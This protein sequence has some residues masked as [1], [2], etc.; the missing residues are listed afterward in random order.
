MR[1]NEELA[2]RACNHF[3]LSAS[4]GSRIRAFA[5]LAMS[6]ALIGFSPDVL[7]ASSDDFRSSLA[8]GQDHTVFVKSDGT[9]WAYG[10]NDRG[11]LGD[12]TTA[13]KR[14]PV[15]IGS[16]TNWVSVSAGA[17]HTLALKANGTIWAWGDNTSFQTGDPFVLYLPTPKQVTINPGGP[18]AVNNDWIA[19]DAGDDHNVALRSD[20]SLWVWGRN[21]LG[22]LGTGDTAVRRTPTRLGSAN[23]WIAAAAGADH[24]LG[25]KVDGRLFAWGANQW[26]QLGD[27]TT[28]QRV[29]PV[30]V[31]V[32]GGGGLFDEDWVAVDAGRLHSL[33]MKSNG[34]LW[35]WGANNYG[36]LGVFVSDSCFG[37][38]D[39][40]KSPRR[41][42]STPTGPG[43][44]NSW[45]HFSAGDL[46]SAALKSDGSLWS[47]G[48]NDS[49][50]LGDGTTS[51]R[52][53]PVKV[54]VA[55]DWV[56]VQAGGSHSVGVR[57]NG[58][59]LGWG[60]NVYGQ[61]GDGTS[62]PEWLDP[63][64]TGDDTSNWVSV[65]SAGSYTLAVRSDGTLWS[66]GDNQ[67]GQLGDGTPAD[68]HFAARLGTDRDWVAVAAG[69][70]HAVALKSD[71]S[72]YAWGR[73]A[74]GQLGD[75]TNFDR[76]S[77]VRVGTDNDWQAIA[78]GSGHTVALKS[79]GSLWTW[80]WNSGG[81]L[82]D[83]STTDTNLPARIG[84]DSDWVRISAST[85]HSLAL[86]S[87]GSLWGWGDNDLGSLGTGSLDWELSPVRIGADNDWTDIS[88]GSTHTLALKAD[89]TIWA[90]GSNFAGEL[91]RG[92]TSTYSA[93]PG[94]AGTDDDWVSIHAGG[95]TSTAIKSNGTRWSWGNNNSGQFGNDSTMGETTPVQVGTDKDWVSLGAGGLFSVALKSDGTLWFTGR[96][97][98]G[99]FG[100]GDTDDSLVLIPGG[101]LTIADAGTD[102]FVSFADQVTLDGSNSWTVVPG[103]LDYE[104]TCLEGCG[105]LCLV[106]EQHV[107]PIPLAE[108]VIEDIPEIPG[109]P[110]PPWPGPGVSREFSAPPR[111]GTIILQ[112]R[113]QD[114]YGYSDTDE[115]AVTVFEDVNHA[116]FVA[117]DGNDLAAG[118]MAQPL[119]SIEAAVDRAA[120]FRQCADSGAACS[121][122]SECSGRCV[123]AD[124][125]LQ[126]GEYPA[127][128]TV[129]LQNHMSLFGGY[130]DDWTRTSATTTTISGAATAVSAVGILDP[131]FI[132]GL[133]IKSSDGVSPTDYGFGENSTALY[134]A[135]A[136]AALAIT[137]NLIEAG[138]GGSGGPAPEYDE[139]AASGAPGNDGENG[140]PG[141]VAVAITANGGSGG[142]SGTAGWFGGD[143]GACGYD[144][145]YAPPLV[146][147]ADDG[148]N[149][150]DS[151]LGGE[152]GD[153]CSDA[154]DGVAGRNGTAGAGGEFAPAAGDIFFDGLYAWRGLAGEPGGAGG[155]GGGGGG[156]AAGD[157]S[158]QY[159][160]IG[161][162]PVPVATF[163]GGGGGGGGEGGLGG[164]P[165]S[166][167]ISGSA[168]FG[169]F[170]AAASPSISHNQLVTAGGGAGGDGGDGQ[171]GGIG[172]PGG[173]GGDG[174][175]TQSDS[176]GRGGD[177]G[178]GGQGGGGGGGSGGPSFGIYDAEE[179]TPY[180]TANCYSPAFCTAPAVDRGIGLGGA[181]GAGGFPNGQP[182]LEGLRGEA[183]QDGVY[184]C[185]DPIPPPGGQG[186][187]P[188]DVDPPCS[189]DD[190]DLVAGIDWGGSDITMSLQS[191]TGR[192]IDR[193]T[194]AVD[195]IRQTGATFERYTVLRAEPGTWQV[196]I[197]GLDVPPEGERVALSVT[198]EGSNDAPVA[199]CQDVT[200]PAGP[201]CMAHASVDE[202]SYDPDPDD[203]LSVVE[204]PAGPFGLGVTLVSLT[205]TDGDGLSAECEALVTVADEAA[206]RIE[207]PD[208]VSVAAGPTC[209]VALALP[210]ATASDACDASVTTSSN[211]PAEFPIGTTVVTFSAVD[212][213]GL[214]AFC[215]TKVEVA[216]VT[217]PEITCPPDVV[218]DAP[219]TRDMIGVASAADACGQTPVVTSDAPEQLPLGEFEVTWFAVD[220][221]GNSASCTQQ[222]TVNE[223]P[224]PVQCDLDGD[225]DVDLDDVMV[226]FALR[227]TYSPP[228][229]PAADVNGDGMITI[230]D[231]RDCVLRCT[232]PRC[233][234]Q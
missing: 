79:D 90:W 19:I 95:S 232:L 20:G 214:A 136:R 1:R 155:Y 152:G 211:A 221:V 31:L 55:S 181:G 67:Y 88:T 63:Q 28:T 41:L 17:A 22:Q 129:A 83:G 91:G 190:C 128:N 226:I 99:Q 106:R 120:T 166:G 131:T 46:H 204:V 11:Q 168:S 82:G 44:E 61:L 145:A 107:G 5:Y 187:D 149:G 195:V 105:D 38:S 64:P 207:C 77:P 206:P 37:G 173:V 162:V 56:D 117:V 157:G 21:D 73:N 47:W 78:V 66:W 75:G 25:L 122:D 51:Q 164:D 118:T 101:L 126:E 42:G 35:A 189:T 229:D 139:R 201:T 132:D 216:D 210:D 92:T 93:V 7:A 65:S 146:C 34:T 102:Q 184:V 188:V 175:P 12:G 138:L 68:R 159:T 134:V 227:G 141:P 111:V 45:S 140:S 161:V 215:R 8:T 233:A 230:N 24:T 53:T 154:E 76:N 218:L 100:T 212:D 33:A 151:F 39:C 203:A 127:A 6:I 185:T 153:A 200:V 130:V 147:G 18:T 108:R 176:G 81:Q 135:N 171:L 27:G 208:D 231:G 174:I 60:S 113:V 80:G 209:Q 167:G 192:I 71:G 87:D 224:L 13:D 223:T 217:A 57:S 49:G 186:P 43:T 177:G 97:R 36:Q 228:S 179:S 165:G 194:K 2:R 86:K 156:G 110:L 4:P 193:S 116:V 84:I 10:K 144:C 30:Q 169:V 16:D 148:E 225:F 133:H 69:E 52:S 58:T 103:G 48:R 183:T 219:A 213:A 150:E 205:A 70:T 119:A 170:L 96:N 143:G 197:V 124:I 180:L 114:S 32:P 50:Q 54:G 142:R 98:D 62:T 59:I 112:L 72:L 94:Q 9:L 172:G 29:T 137:N 121:D 220:E 15:Q 182:G 74:F 89:G 163:T 158:V 26:G 40:M 109:N 104:W 160:I 115:M 234:V 222:V 199:R 125:Y 14:S 191:P 202:G 123:P 198:R 178:P 85:G 23:D 3:F 196:R